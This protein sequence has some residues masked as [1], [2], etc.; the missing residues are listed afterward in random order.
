[1]EWETAARVCIYTVY[2]SRIPAKSCLGIANAPW[3]SAKVIVVPI[4][5][6]HKMIV[7]NKDSLIVY[8]EVSLTR[9]E[10]RVN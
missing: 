4:P 2:W 7:Y 3:R 8:N 5:A 10:R 6:K 9:A 1:M